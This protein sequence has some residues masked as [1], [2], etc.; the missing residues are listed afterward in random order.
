MPNTADSLTH[1]VWQSHRNAALAS[2][3]DAQAQR[4]KDPETQA[5]AQAQ[6]LAFALLSLEQETEAD[7]ILALRGHHP[8][9]PV[10]VSAQPSLDE[11]AL[12]F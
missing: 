4:A 6:A 2:M 12:L 9:E 1:L 7:L 5:H 11:F 10:L 8:D 3:A